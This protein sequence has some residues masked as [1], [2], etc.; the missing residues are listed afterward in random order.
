MGL[1]SL[2]FPHIT[3]EMH[4]SKNRRAFRIAVTELTVLSSTNLTQFPERN[5][6]NRRHR[7]TE[8]VV[9]ELELLGKGTGRSLAR[10]SECTPRQWSSGELRPWSYDCAPLST[11]TQSHPT[12]CSL[13]FRLLLFFRPS[14]FLVSPNGHTHIHISCSL[15]E[16]KTLRRSLLDIKQTEKT[17]ER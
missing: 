15:R 3:H 12:L 17:A 8:G 9:W 2:T 10:V 1:N 6:A 14:L 16:R 13:S 4:G 7:G 5:M 11:I